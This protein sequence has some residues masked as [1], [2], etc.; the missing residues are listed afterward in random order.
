[1]I[2]P[3]IIKIKISVLRI[4]SSLCNKFKRIIFRRDYFFGSFLKA[5]KSVIK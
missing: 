5:V 4:Y 3:A 2:V 1:M